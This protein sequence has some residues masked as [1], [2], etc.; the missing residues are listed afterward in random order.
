MDA[1]LSP[2]LIECVE[3]ACRREADRVS[4]RMRRG[5]WILASIAASAF[6]VG[7]FGT[8]LG[9]FGCFRS[10]GTS[11]TAALIAITSTLAESLLP[12]LFGFLVAIAS[13]WAYQY[14]TQQAQSLDLEMRNAS[15]DLVNRLIVCLR[16]SGNSTATYANLVSR[17]NRERERTFIWRAFTS[18]RDPQLLIK[19]IHRN[20]VLELLWPQIR[21][22]FEADCSLASGM[23]ILFAYAAIG[24]LT[25]IAQG[26]ATAGMV[27]GAFLALAALAVRT[28]SRRAIAGIVIFFVFAALASVIPFGPTISSFCLALAPVLLIGCSKAVRFPTSDQ[29]R[30]LV[31]KKARRAPA[32]LFARKSNEATLD[33]R[34]PHTDAPNVLYVS[35][36]QPTRIAVPGRPLFEHA[37]RR[38]L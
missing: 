33:Y 5:L 21:S 6:F 16:R 18:T 31:Q 30:N 14:W 2:Y 12:M 23:W 26:R 20:G 17:R 4:G 1:A 35:Q 11:R 25:C 13:F 22:P 37:P 36:G 32:L 10:L 8:I 9:A 15:V 19:R 24:W 7:T 38:S 29:D 28:G 3:L 34:P 27:V